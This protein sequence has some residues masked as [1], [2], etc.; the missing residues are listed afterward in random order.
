[1]PESRQHMNICGLV[2][3]KDGDK[4]QAASSFHTGLPVG[5]IY[6]KHR[7]EVFLSAEFLM[8]TTGS[9]CPRPFRDRGSLRRWPGIPAAEALGLRRHWAC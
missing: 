4:L 3:A 5:S 8:S 6:A 1:M 9:F 7:T 2:G